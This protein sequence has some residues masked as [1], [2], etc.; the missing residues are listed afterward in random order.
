MT[1]YIENRK[2]STHKLL[3]L[4]NELSKVVGYKINIEKYSVF[5]ILIM[6]YERQQIKS[7]SYLKS[8]QGSSGCG[9]VVMN[10]ASIHEYVVQSLASF[11]GLRIWHC[12]ELWCRSKMQL[13]S[14]IAVTVP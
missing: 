8:H 5:Y 9:S 4:R 13:K 14:D 12:H 11:S 7:H 3:R 6:N 10:L 1:V 2:V